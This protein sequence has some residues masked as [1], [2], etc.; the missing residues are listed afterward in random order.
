MALMSG[1]KG[2]A[3]TAPVYS[4]V[5]GLVV[6]PQMKMGDPGGGGEEMGGG[7]FQMPV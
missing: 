6:I 5:S 7:R 1:K 2:W 3:T 4:L